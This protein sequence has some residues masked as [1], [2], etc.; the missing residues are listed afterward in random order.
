M[1]K[2]I[3]CYSRG[4]GFIPSTHTAKGSNTLFWP[5]RAL[6]AGDEQYLLWVET[7]SRTHSQVASRELRIREK[8]T[9]LS[10]HRLME[11]PGGWRRSSVK[12]CG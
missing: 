11:T 12:M 5:L 4:P 6:H 8:T 2:N 10:T 7:A 3:D 9:V 1:V